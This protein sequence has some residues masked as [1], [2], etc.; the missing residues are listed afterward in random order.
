[1]EDS[2]RVCESCIHL[3][4]DDDSYWMCLDCNDKDLW[5]DESEYDRIVRRSW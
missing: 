3:S 1:M 4:C 2:E 5:E